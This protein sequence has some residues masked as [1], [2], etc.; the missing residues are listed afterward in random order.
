M[1]WHLRHNRALHENVVVLTVLTDSR[2]RVQWPERMSIVRESD[3]FWR[4]TAHYGFMQRPDIP[5]LLKEAQ[6]RGCEVKLDD[7]T[8]YVGHESILHRQHGAALPRWQEALF[9]A[10]VRNAAH[11]TDYFRLPSEQV[12]EI[13]RQISI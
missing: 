7:V 1:R 9:A 12:V 11:V 2:P 3:G 6:Q 5:L 13:G 10:M 4:V 8:Y